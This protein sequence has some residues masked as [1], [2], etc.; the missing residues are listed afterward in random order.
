MATERTSSSE[1]VAKEPA[2]VNVDVVAASA[3]DRKDG[4]DVDELGVVSNDVMVGSVDTSSGTAASS[5]ITAELEV[6]GAA[7]A[8]A[9]AVASPVGGCTGGENP[10]MSIPVRNLSGA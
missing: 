6:S 10:S 4:E 5:S 2:D 8:A 9:S 3:A 1:G 7:S